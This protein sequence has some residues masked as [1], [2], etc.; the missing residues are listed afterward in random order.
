MFLFITFQCEGGFSSM[1]IRFSV[2][3]S[4]V[5]VGALA[6][7]SGCASQSAQLREESAPAASVKYGDF[8]DPQQSVA[9]VVAAAPATRKAPTI[10]VEAAQ[11]TSIAS[12]GFESGTAPDS[13]EPGYAA[14]VSIPEVDIAAE[15]V[16]VPADKSELQLIEEKW[17]SLPESAK[18]DILYIINAATKK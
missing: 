5:A 8:K 7:I 10:E 4:S 14:V 2:I 12:A 18:T 6:L 9:P 3:V 17:K 1:S 15:A 16:S 11:Y 13:A